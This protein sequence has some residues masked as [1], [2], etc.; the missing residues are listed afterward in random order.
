MG[1]KDLAER[2]TLRLLRASRRVSETVGAVIAEF[3]LTLDQWLVLELLVDNSG[4]G[5]AMSDI[6]TDT[7]LVGATLTR[8]VDKLV[9]NALAHREVDPHDRRRVVMHASRDGVELY[10]RSRSAV[11]ASEA[12]VAEVF[13]SI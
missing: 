10:R 7:G 3:G 2:P 1:E 9:T 5:L 11:D 4:T 12:S 13:V 8:T 6:R